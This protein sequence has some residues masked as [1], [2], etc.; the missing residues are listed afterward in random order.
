M[1]VIDKL[2]NNA[3]RNVRNISTMGYRKS[4]AQPP[5]CTDPQHS[6]NPTLSI[7][8]TLYKSNCSFLTENLMKATT[9]VLSTSSKSKSKPSS[10][11]DTYTTKTNSFSPTLGRSR[12]ASRY[13]SEIRRKLHPLPTI[14]SSHSD[15]ESVNYII[16]CPSVRPRRSTSAP[17]SPAPHRPAPPI[18]LDCNN[19]NHVIA[20]AE[21]SDH[22]EALPPT[23][24]QGT[25]RYRRNAWKYSVIELY[26]L[27]KHCNLH[28]IANICN[29]HLFDGQFFAN[30]D[31][32]ELLQDQPFS[33]SNIQI[34][35]IKRLQ[36]GW[37]RVLKLYSR[38][39]D[40]VRKATCYEL[41]SNVVNGL[42]R[43]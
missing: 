36:D 6:N 41:S 28:D 20:N 32:Q 43:G 35:K 14:V 26:H 25:Q 4:P 11:S 22:P 5:G 38:Y 31:V 16:P 8:S 37:L 33:A 2:D 13:P 29:E 40:S 1:S 18:P 34:L 9:I 10:P 19:S 12:S 17:R 24:K 27:L 39:T 7:P 21:P 23:R 3:T 15:E 42:D 30:L